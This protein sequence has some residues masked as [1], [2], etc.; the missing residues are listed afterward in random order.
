MEDTNLGQKESSVYNEAGLQ[1]SRL[2]N[3][4]VKIEDAIQKGNL[5]SWKFLLD[6]VW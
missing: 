2:H 3:L 6:G 5:V 1:I 4:W